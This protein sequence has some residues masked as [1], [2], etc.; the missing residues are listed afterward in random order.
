MKEEMEE[1]EK[2]HEPEAVQGQ[3]RKKESGEERLQEKQQ[4]NKRKRN[5]KR[6]RQRGWV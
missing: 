2:G 5:R 4:E 6:N 1:T 3:K